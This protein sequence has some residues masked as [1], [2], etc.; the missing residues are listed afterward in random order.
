MA[1]SRRGMKYDRFID[2]TKILGLNRD[3]YKAYLEDHHVAMVMFY[4][5]KCP[6]C[7]RVKPHFL[8]AA[9]VTKRE[10]STY[11]AVDCTLEPELC[12]QELVNAL[13]TIKLYSK[14]RVI[15]SYNSQVD[16]KMLQKHIENAPVAARLP[17]TDAYE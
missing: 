1:P 14:G 16:Y 12:S 3:S 9:Y 5:P 2:S 13:P 10:G 7:Q 17:P 11:A 4:D 15:S 8:K 6:Q